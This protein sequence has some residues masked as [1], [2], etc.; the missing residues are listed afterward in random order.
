MKLPLIFTKRL[1]T[2]P[3]AL[4]WG[5]A[6]MFFWI[7]MGAFIESASVSN[8]S[9]VYYTASWYGIIALLATSSFATSIA[10]MI[11]YQ[12]GSLSYFT[13]FSKLTPKYYLFSLYFT[14]LVTTTVVSVI[15]GLGVVSLFSYHFGETIAPKNW[16]L[17][18]LDAIL[19]GVFYLP[20]SLFLEE[21]TVVTSRK[22][23]NA[24][25]FIPIILAYLFGFSYMNINLGNLVYYSPFLSIQVLGMQS[26]FT[27]SIPLN[28]NDFK[29]PTLNVYYAII[30]LIGWS[31]ILSFAS[32]LLFRRLYYRSLEEA[33]IA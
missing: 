16:G 18:F 28:F 32:M 19:S 13:R 14:M 8:S 1:L 12:S 5:I 26:F 11:Y 4:G 6:F 15:M 23:S 10:M 3:Y 17:F 20:L 33:R 22:L 31:I 30:S 29:G 7:A 9:A 25:S 2:N 24:I 21:L 27:K